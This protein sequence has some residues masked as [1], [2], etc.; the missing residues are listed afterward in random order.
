[1][2]R[3]AHFDEAVDELEQLRA[4]FP[5]QGGVV[6][7]LAY[8]R[9]ELK[10]KKGSEGVTR[11]AAEA[12]ELNRAQRFLEAIPL[13]EN[14]LKEYPDDLVLTRLL[15]S[16]Y[17]D[18]QNF[19]RESALRAG[20]E[21]CEGLQRRG[22]WQ[23]ALDLIA[24]LIS[25]NPGN[26]ELQELAVK[27]RQEKN[28]A[29][30]AA[31]VRAAVEQSEKL[32]RDGRPDVAV[33]GVEMAILAF[34]PEQ[35]LT[36]LLQKAK[37]AQQSQQ[38]R[39]YIEAELKHASV[40]EERGDLATSLKIVEGALIRFPKSP[41][42]LA[43]S[44]RL[45][46]LQKQ[47][48]RGLDNELQL[49]RN[50]HCQP[51][52]RE[53]RRLLDAG[54]IAEAEQLLSAN[55]ADYGDI[56]DVMKLGSDILAA[57]K[58][59]EKQQAIA[60]CLRQAQD[61]ESRNDL[62][63]AQD[64]LRRALDSYPHDS[65]L[66]AAHG[67]LRDRILRDVQRTDRPPKARSAR[68]RFRQDRNG[69]FMRLREC[70][71]R[72]WPALGLDPAPD[73]QSY[74]RKVELCVHARRQ[75]GGKDGSSGRDGFS[76]SRPDLLVFARRHCRAANHCYQRQGYSGSEAERNLGHIYAPQCQTGQG[77]V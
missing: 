66:E 56:P 24:L 61:L 27:A 69:G 29:E 52:V 74:S 75:P 17:L 46:A 14:G 22:H 18:L 57:K 30:R 19:E 55:L 28:R 59:R 42:L 70:S 21:R 43:A 23:E 77:G 72:D 40:F 73:D 67:K 5:N 63:G 25:D 48:Q 26:H 12:A 35:A 9:Q 53:G 6:D 41:E 11:I 10:G 62:I 4:S 38:N 65:D 68:A 50:E 36:A 13:I 32:L 7:L 47:V 51:L 58:L 71:S 3:T 37:D 34:G 76:A 44:E 60:E 54:R 33:S 8:A 2:L 15:R 49:D 31:A 39:Q 45:A 20:V 16:T 1:M 64:I